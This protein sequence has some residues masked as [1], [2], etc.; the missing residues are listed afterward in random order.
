V[1]LGFVGLSQAAYL[2]NI[3]PLGQPKSLF[4]AGTLPVLNILVGTEVLGGLILAV[5]EFLRQAL[6]VQETGT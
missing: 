1:I 2:Q 5:T 3:L 4:S 6:E